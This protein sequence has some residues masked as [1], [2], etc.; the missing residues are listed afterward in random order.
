MGLNDYL[1]PDHHEQFL[2]AIATSSIERDPVDSKAN[3]YLIADGPR[4]WYRHAGEKFAGIPKRARAKL[5]TVDNRSVVHLFIIQS[6]PE[7]EDFVTTNEEQLAKKATDINW[8][9]VPDAKLDQ[10]STGGS[11]D[12][13]NVNENDFNQMSSFK[14]DAQGVL[15]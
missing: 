10:C 11:E 1:T 13:L 4:V 2:E 3:T 9:A 14:H 12:K 8:F 6:I 15:R 5:T 7:F